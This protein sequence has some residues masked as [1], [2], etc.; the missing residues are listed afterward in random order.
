MASTILLKSSSIKIKLAACLAISVPFLPIAIPICA[1]FNA[2]PSFK[3]SPVIA[4]IWLLSFSAWMIFN[5]ASGN[6]LVKMVVSITFTFKVAS[7][8]AINSSPFNTLS[9]SL[10]PICFAIVEVVA[11]LSPVT[12]FT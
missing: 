11:A 3:P 8:I 10:K 4:T 6:I 2:G 12:I 7:S 1:D 9:L 5:L